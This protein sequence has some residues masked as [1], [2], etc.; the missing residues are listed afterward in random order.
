MKKIIFFSILFLSAIQFIKIDCQP[1]IKSD[2]KNEIIAPPN[3]KAILKKSCYDCHSNSS[4]IPWYGNIA[5]SS[6]LVRLHI[7]DGR[8]YLNFSTF[9]ALSKDKQKDK[10][11]KIEESIVIRMPLQSYLWIHKNAVLSDIDKK[12]L[13]EWIKSQK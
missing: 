11:E 9:N 7:N 1:N 3:I 6:W 12:I 4:V 10:Y 5:P 8:H 13:K 2:P